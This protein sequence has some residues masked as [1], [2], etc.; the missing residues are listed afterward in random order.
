MNEWISV[1]DRLPDDEHETLLVVLQS[2]V[3]EAHSGEQF[4]DTDAF[5]TSDGFFQF[6][7]ESEEYEVTHWM[8]LPEP[9]TNG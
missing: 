1:D 5:Y 9:P 3:E 8:P 2:I 6:W 4:V 7:N